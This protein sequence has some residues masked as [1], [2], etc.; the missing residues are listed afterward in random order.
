VTGTTSPAHPTS[1]PR[2]T[3]ARSSQA[4]EDVRQYVPMLSL[5]SRSLRQLSLLMRCR[6]VA[7]LCIAA[8]L[9]LAPAVCRAQGQAA[10]EKL[11]PELRARLQGLDRSEEIR[12]SVV[13]D[14]ADVPSRR[15][16]AARRSA[17][18][19]RQQRV[20]D[21]LPAG[22]LRIGRRY[23]NL[24]GFAG[25]GG[26]AAIE[27]LARH[28]AVAHV[29]VDRKAYASLAQGRLLTGA[30][31]AH[32]VGVTGNGIVVAVIDTGIDTDHADLVDDLIKEEQQCWCE[33]GGGPL[34][35]CCPNGAE[36]QSGENSAEDDNGHGTSVSGIIT[37]AG[38]SAGLG[39]APDA[40][41]VAL[42]VLD[43][44][45]SGYFSDIAAALDW[46]LN[47]HARLGVRVV[48][49]SLGDGA[50]YS[51]ALASPCSGSNTAN[52]IR[53]LVGEGVVVFASSG[54]EAYDDGISLPAC[55]PEAI[56]VGGVYDANLGGVSWC[57]ATCDTTLCTD[58]PTFSDKFVCHTNSDELL[59]LLAPDWRTATSRFG[60]GSV[61]FGGTSAAAPYASALAVLLIEQN[62]TRTPAD[63]RTLMTSHGPMVSNPDNGLSF[64]R[65][66]VEALFVVCG[67]DEV[68]AG[69]DCDDGNTADGDCCSSTCVF[70]PAGS[71][72]DD[73]DACTTSDACDGAGVCSQSTALDCDDQLFCN[74]VET[75]DS[76]SGCQPGTPPVLEDGVSCTL[77]ACDE[78]NDIV[79]HTP[80]DGACDDDAWCNG[81]EVCDLLLD[82]QTGTPPPLD[83]SVLCTIDACDETNDVVVHTPD[84]GACADSTWCNGAGVCDSIFDCQPGTP[85]PLDDSVFCTIDACDETNDVVIHIEYDPRCDD[86]DP[87]TADLCDAVAGCMSTPISGC[88]VA[89][90]TGGASPGLLWLMLAASGLGA[91]GARRRTSGS[92]R[93]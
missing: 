83:D 50:E 81:A 32:A 41:I 34:T 40:D 91:L 8:L 87:C 1:K 5:R 38:V 25:R 78:A 88:S 10:L 44:D 76:G 68:E 92:E 12:V 47:N 52:A 11:G 42:K 49:L 64:P 22:V 33:G 17:I 24:A 62:P 79:T 63:L 3:L 58:S 61:N 36:T 84:D 9:W 60:G 4:S 35:G 75:C 46:L 77:D 54:N 86:G 28:P 80:D 48:N 21:D 53:D 43:A 31:S 65:T 27:A 66:D 69:E 26:P 85:P 51:N 7:A 37:S 39:V 74:G 70:E 90:P 67:N 82:C 56:S 72:C 14:E 13:L 93:P 71:G 57:G 19:A 2:F 45:G 20:F 23:E 30:T 29:S 6:L 18:R 89:L 59:D 16:A 55:V 73:G 15:S